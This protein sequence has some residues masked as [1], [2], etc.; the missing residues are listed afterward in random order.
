LKDINIQETLKALNTD[1]IVIFE[2]FF[3]SV[4]LQELNQEYEKILSDKSVQFPENKNAANINESYLSKNKLHALYSAFFS[5]QFITL[6]S[7][8]WGKEFEH[9]HD[10]YVMKDIEGSYNIAQDLHFDIIK[11]LKF[12]IYLNDIDENNGAFEYVAGSHKWTEKLRENSPNEINFK[13]REISRNLPKEYGSSKPLI[14]KAG[15]VFIFDTNMFHRAGEFKS[16]V[17]KII[18]GHT[19]NH[20]PGSQVDNGLSAYTNNSFAKKALRKLLRVFSI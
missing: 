16:G 5:T 3:N 20:H 11:Q 19:W 12:F 9:C 7:E 6:S 15:T 4:E 2:N 8:V 17:R 10:I 13:N 1:G 14:A 18:R